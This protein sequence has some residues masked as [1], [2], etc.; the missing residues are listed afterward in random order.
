MD[1]ASGALPGAA[2][3]LGARKCVMTQSVPPV[4]PASRPRHARVKRTRIGDVSSRRTPFHAT[5]AILISN[6]LICPQA[7]KMV[8]D[9]AS[10]M[11]IM[12]GMESTAGVRLHNHRRKL[13]Q[14]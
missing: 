8:V 3:S 7:V 4:T 11:N 12:G 9:K 14:R 5:I 1:L 10:I 13:R 6:S 2:V